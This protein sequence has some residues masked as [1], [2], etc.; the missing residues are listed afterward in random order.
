MNPKK[1]KKKEK[2]KN[3]LESAR[4]NSTLLSKEQHEVSDSTTKITP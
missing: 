2:L 4:E 1:E 3:T